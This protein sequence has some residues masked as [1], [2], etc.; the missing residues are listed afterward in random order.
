M[1][2]YYMTTRVDDKRQTRTI[3]RSLSLEGAKREASKHYKDAPA[4]TIIQIYAQWHL[5]ERLSLVA[6]KYGPHA[7]EWDNYL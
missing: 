5:N 4:E 3:C 7:K 6:E 1:S 2:R